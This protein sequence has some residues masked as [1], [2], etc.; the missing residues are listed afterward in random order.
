[1]VH[2]SNT[3]SL[4]EVKQADI[5]MSILQLNS[6]LDTLVDY[7]K[8]T[9]HSHNANLLA[10]QTRDL[11]EKLDAYPNY[12]RADI[13]LDDRIKAVGAVIAEINKGITSSLH[14]ALIFKKARGAAN[15]ALY[16]TKPYL[17]LKIEGNKMP[18]NNSQAQTEQTITLD[19]FR[20]AFAV[21]CHSYGDLDHYYGFSQF[22]D[23][24]RIDW[25]QEAIKILS[26]ELKAL[27]VGG[28][29]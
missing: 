18:Q 22:V 9:D 5:A 17:D 1:M 29:K 12:Q 27:R 2:M 25:M 7:T 21:V 14:W 4:T 6:A 16:D 19:Q 13:S 23:S 26:K 20:K 11:I 28:E 10:E 15:A 24:K 8:S 3:A